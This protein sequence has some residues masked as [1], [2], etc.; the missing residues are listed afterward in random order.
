MK[1]NDLISIVIPVYNASKYI[2]E[3]I[4]SI[5]NQT[6][7]NYEAIFI[8]DGSSDNSVEIIEKHKSQNSKIKIIK[9]SHQG[10]SKA[11]NIGI[12]NAKGRFL[13]FLDSDD[14]WLESKLEKQIEFVKENDYAF[15][16]CNFKYL[17]DDGRKLSKEI[18]AGN[19]TDY[20]KALKN[21]RILTATAMIDLNK[22]S[23]ELCYMPDV[24]NEDIVTWWKILKNDYIAYGQDEVLAYY[25][26]TKN[27]RSSKKH[28][29]SYYRWKLYR[30]QEKLGI[31]KSIYYFTNY[32]I[33][34]IIKRSSLKRK[35]NSSKIQVAI[36]TQ[37]LKNESDVDKLLKKMNIKNQFLIIN[38]TSSENID[39]KNKKVITKNEKG[40]SRSR[41][42]VIENATEDII[43]IA[44][45]DVIYNNRY[46]EIILKAWNKYK[47]ADII[48]FYVESKN[49]KR[50][51]KRMRTGKI[52]YI[53]AMRIV[54]F[55][56]SFK[57][58]SIQE[59]K[60][61]FNENFGA[62]TENNRGE[63]QIFLY[64]AIRK[65][66]KVIFVNKKIGEAGQKESTWFTGYNPEFFKI[67]GKI[68]KKMSAKYY[69]IL[70]LQYA[71][72]KYFLYNKEFSMR[73]AIKCMLNEIRS[74]N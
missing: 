6:Y 27:S 60:L 5:E 66:M 63:E 7:Q 19:K 48:C 68:F 38:Q 62:G 67:Q 59:N 56:I 72:R 3:T 23:K 10:V 50:K 65:G 15:V 28:I 14:I 24:M 70:I 11:R 31:F 12:K 1:C 22:I 51:I 26:Q 74:D 49:A 40:L 16:Y 2:E 73:Q 39:I 18:K 35:I 36:S 45:D 13:T 37:N 29:T 34:A 9:N 4:K 21:I 43:L 44:D 42:T 20:N 54:S 25:R 32:V 41:N 58:K 71:I 17:S 64:E 55:E 53:R 33:N 8:D 46:E 30:E 52:G 69:K 57:K 47:N 61:K